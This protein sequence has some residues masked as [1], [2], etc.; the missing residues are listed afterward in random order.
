MDFAYYIGLEASNELETI[1]DKQSFSINNK[2]KYEKMNIINLTPETWQTENINELVTALINFQIAF[3]KVS[4]KK[5]SKNPFLKNTYVSLDNLINTT[6]PLLAANGLVITQELAGKSLVTTLLHSSGQFKG[7]LYDFN[8][9]D[10]SKG[11]NSLQEQGGGITYAKRYTWSALLGVSVDTD[12]DGNQ[13]NQPTKK[14]APKKNPTYPVKNYTKGANGIF[15][16]KCTLADIKANFVVSNAAEKTI[17][18]M[19]AQLIDQQENQK[20]IK[21]W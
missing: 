8:P 5:D 11:T 10:S 14:Q 12:T 20:Q 7:S 17:L 16:G 19:V 3:Q 9:M 13:P 1:I 15:S 21:Q 2:P 4:L 6:R 18:N